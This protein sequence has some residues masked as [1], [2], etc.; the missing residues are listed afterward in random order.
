MQLLSWIPWNK[1]RGQNA[2]KIKKEIKSVNYR[3]FNNLEQR[4]TVGASIFAALAQPII[5]KN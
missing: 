4:L 1:N 5:I 3:N 2:I